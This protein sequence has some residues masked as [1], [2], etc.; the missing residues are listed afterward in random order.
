MGLDQSFG[1]TV[2]FKGRDLLAALG[3]VNAMLA[4]PDAKRVVDFLALV[5]AGAA[6]MGEVIVRGMAVSVVPSDD[7]LALIDGRAVDA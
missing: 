5:E 3:S 1:L 2:G 7:L 4:G 6:T